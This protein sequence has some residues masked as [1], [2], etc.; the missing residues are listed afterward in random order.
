MNCSLVPFTREL[1]F[2]LSSDFL[3]GNTMPVSIGWEHTSLLTM[4]PCSRP[5]PPSDAAPSTSPHRTWGPNTVKREQRS[6]RAWAW[7]AGMREGVQNTMETYME[8]HAEQALVY[9]ISAQKLLNFFCS[10]ICLVRVRRLS[11][12][13]SERSEISLAGRVVFCRKL[14]SK[15]DL[16]KRAKQTLQKSD[17]NGIGVC[18]AGREGHSPHLLWTNDQSVSSTSSCW[19]WCSKGQSAFE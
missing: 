13:K 10:E 17:D 2:N 7:V 19:N 18:C 11:L 14:E 1:F 3:L 15:R 4:V 6:A 16:A 8:T 9:Q 12:Q 5:V